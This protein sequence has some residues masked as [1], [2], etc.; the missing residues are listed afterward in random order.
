MGPAPPE[1]LAL[2]AGSVCVG[3]AV[4]EAVGLPVPVSVPVGLGVA[5]PLEDQVEVVEGEDPLD[6]LPVGLAEGV[7]EGVAVLVSVTV[8][9]A[10]AVG[11]GGGVPGGVPSALGL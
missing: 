7:G 8:A 11:E 9:V 10:V 4:R 6:R 5:E 3:L 2:P 1:L